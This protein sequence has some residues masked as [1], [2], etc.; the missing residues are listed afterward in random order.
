M[1]GER[2]RVAMARNAGGEVDGMVGRRSAR[3]S[4]ERGKSYVTMCFYRFL[5]EDDRLEQIRSGHIRQASVGCI[6]PYT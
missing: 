3:R 1:G 6:E 5:V 2:G 4:V